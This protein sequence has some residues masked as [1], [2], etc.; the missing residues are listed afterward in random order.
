M[1]KIRNLR[2]PFSLIERRMKKPG[3]CLKLESCG[4]LWMGQWWSNILHNLNI[5]DI[6]SS[7]SILLESLLFL[8]LHFCTL[9]QRLHM[10]TFISVVYIMAHPHPHPH[11]SLI[12]STATNHIILNTIDVGSMW[13]TSSLI[14][15]DWSKYF[16]ATLFSVYQTSMYSKYHF[17]WLWNFRLDFDKWWWYHTVRYRSLTVVLDRPN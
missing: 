15:I 4:E 13:F 12:A 1:K 6:S 17:P 9:M 7:T 8:L 16:T 14:C 3:W 10:N 11:G 2:V 5:R